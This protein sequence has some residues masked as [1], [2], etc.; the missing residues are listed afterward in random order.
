MIEIAQALQ[1]V[2]DLTV[3]SISSNGITE[4]AAD[5]IAAVLSHNT[6][7]QTLDIHNNNLRTTGAMKI[8]QALKI[9]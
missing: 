8:T 2:S 3:L 9:L 6:Q 4:E 1:N 5:D 7:L